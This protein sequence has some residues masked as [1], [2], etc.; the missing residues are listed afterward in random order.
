MAMTPDH[1]PTRDASRLDVGV[2]SAG[3]VGSV[4]GAALSTA[5]H[6]VI[7]T[8][9]VSRA[10]R[11]RAARFI[12]DAAILPADEVAHAASLLLLA[13]PDDEIADLVRGLASGGHLRAGQL[14]AHVSGGHGADVLA[15]A[16]ELGAATMAIH[17]AMTFTGRPED[18]DRLSGVTF[19]VTAAEEFRPIAAALVIEMGGE[20]EFVD[21]AKR[22]LYH[23]ALCHGAN[24]LN[25]LIG[26]AIDQLAAAGV[27]NPQRMI[28]PLLS[29]ALDNALRLG[30][31][32][33]TGPVARGDAGT[34]SAHLRALR[35]DAPDTVAPYIAMARRTADRAIDSG[36]LPADT[37]EPLLGALAHR[38]RGGNR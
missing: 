32:A 22:P 16:A 14:I 12:P 33:L 1:R 4:L 27:E 6:R 11:D 30:D 37:A 25:T 2:I 21:E 31:A 24:H 20:P 7:A 10:S 36:R 28:A 18:V 8:T 35:D 26:D 15:P 13:V 29:A 5:G 23:A 9:A 38:V 19:A 34:V 17:P 3:R